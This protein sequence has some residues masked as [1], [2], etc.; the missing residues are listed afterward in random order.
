MEPRWY[1]SSIEKARL[2]VRAN[3]L[4]RLRANSGYKR[5]VKIPGFDSGRRNLLEEACW[6]QHLFAVRNRLFGAGAKR[7]LSHFTALRHTLGDPCWIPPVV[8]TSLDRLES[9]LKSLASKAKRGRPSDSIARV[10]RQNM[11]H[12]VPPAHLS[13]KTSRFLSREE[14]DEIFTELVGL[15]LGRTVSV[16]TFTRMQMRE[17]DTS[18]INSIGTFANK[19]A[20]H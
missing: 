16:A 11:H 6:R 7:A 18:E 4:L 20:D 3:F 13:Q 10:F 17:I 14:T 5:L 8:A 19:H 9:D 12:F 1:S 15:V 2:E